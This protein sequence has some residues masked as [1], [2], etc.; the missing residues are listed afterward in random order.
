MSFKRP[1]TALALFTI[2]AVLALPSALA[3]QLASITGTATDPTGAAIPG[4]HVTIKSASTGATYNGVTNGAGT[5]SLTDIK[6]GPDYVITFSHSGFKTVSVSGVYMNV[7]ATRTQNVKLP[8]G[9]QSQTVTVSAASQDVTLDTTNATLGNNFQVQFLQN[10]PIANRDSPS[11]LFTQQP[12]VSSGGNSSQT[13]ATT[14]ARVDQDRVTLDGLDVNDMATGQFGAIVANA[15]V[16]SVQEF[17]GVVAGD[18]SNAMAGGG[19][20]FELVTKSGTNHFHG[21]LNEYHR[22]TDLEANNWFSNNAGVPRAPLIRNQFGGDIGGP[23]L[24][25][26][27]FFY[28]DYNGR[29]DTLSNVETRVV[30]LDS[31]RNGTLT[32][33]DNTGAHQSLSPAQ[34]ASLD[35]LGIGFN[36]ALLKLFSSRYPHANDFSIGDGLNTAGFRFNA[37]FPYKEND[38]VARLDWTINSKMKLFAV[39]HVT[40]INSTQNAIQFPGDPE[41]FP[42]LDKSY[43]WVIGHT[44]AIN[45]HMV[46]QAYLGET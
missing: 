28:F 35:P 27:L 13:G 29:R 32:Y 39:T 14:G 30:P 3:Q 44:W 10:L 42:F 24:K 38:Y 21:D 4:V 12:G 41:T 26:R 18:Q 23:I 46:N 43:S 33:I 36:P 2:L 25:N 40:R 8:L 15:P 11:V 37:P 5:Y 45:D 17:R 20:H 16:D 7:A 34:V 6:P 19:G 1:L 22:D 31:F 9:V